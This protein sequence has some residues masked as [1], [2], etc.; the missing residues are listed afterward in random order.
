MGNKSFVSQPTG[1]IDCNWRL[2]DCYT[3]G[4]RCLSRLAEKQAKYRRLLLIM[5]FERSHSNTTTVNNKHIF[6]II[7]APL[8]IKWVGKSRYSLSCHSFTILGTPFML[9]SKVWEHIY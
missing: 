6:R 3:T 9:V 2:F 7:K 5:I 4:L 1:N 8:D